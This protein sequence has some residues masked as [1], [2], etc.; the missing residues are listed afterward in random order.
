M[1]TLK[2]TKIFNKEKEIP[3]LHEQWNQ[4]TAERFGV[5]RKDCLDR[6]PLNSK[7]WIQKIKLENPF[8]R[9]IHGYMFEYIVYFKNLIIGGQIA[10]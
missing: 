4:A 9:K 3:S 6:W 7:F 5:K 10:F 2:T 1:K 8:V